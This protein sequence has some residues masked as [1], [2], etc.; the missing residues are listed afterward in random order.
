MLDN[1]V[2]QVTM[3]QLYVKGEILVEK[4]KISGS[5]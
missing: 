5:C 4:A 1:V 3:R 2:V